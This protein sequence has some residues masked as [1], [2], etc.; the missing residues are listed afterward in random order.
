MCWE[1]LSG[2]GLPLTILSFSDS[3]Y[4]STRAFAVANATVTF[5]IPSLYVVA[6]SIS[7]PVCRSGF[8][9]NMDVHGVCWHALSLEIYSVCLPFLGLI[10]LLNDRIVLSFRLEYVFLQ[11]LAVDA[12]PYMLTFLPVTNRSLSVYS[13]YVPYLVLGTWALQTAISVVVKSTDP[14]LTK[15]IE[16]YYS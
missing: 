3:G 1:R 13:L 12:S 14:S 8:L 7:G 5:T 15:A 10:S 9:I 16:K 11:I 6:L 4:L 2:Q